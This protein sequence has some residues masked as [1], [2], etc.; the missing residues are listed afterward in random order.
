MNHLSILIVENE[1][2]ES[3]DI[4]QGLESFNYHVCDIAD[5]TLDA[6]KMVEKYL[7]DLVL[8]D[9]NL[10]EKND[11]I[12]ATKII[13]EKYNIPV[14][15]LTAN[16]DQQ[17]IELVKKTRP[18]GFIVKP[19]FNRELN[20]TIKTALYK[21]KIE[22]E[23]KQNR[24][25]LFTILK[26]IR[27][28]VLVVDMENKIK[29]INFAAEQLLGYNEDQISDKYIF[30]YLK[31][32]NTET[33]QYVTKECLNL[34]L[35]NYSDTF[36][37]VSKSGRKT[38]VETN[39]APINDHRGSELGVVYAF[40]DISERQRSHTAIIN[41]EKRYS[42]LV[43]NMSSGVVVYRSCNKGKDFI[44]KEFNKAAEKIES[45]SHTKVLGKNF[46]QCFPDLNNTKFLQVLQNVW[47]DGKPK[48][49][50]LSIYKHNKLIKSY[51]FYVYRLHSGEVISVFN[52]VKEKKQ[53]NEKI[54][55]QASL[56]DSIGEAVVA[57]NQ[58]GII[59]YWNKAA[60]ELYGWSAEESLGMNI[61]QI[62]P[63][64][65]SPDIA[66]EIKTTLERGQQW[67]GE[68][69]ITNR[70][71]LKFPVL[72]IDSPILDKTGK[73]VGIIG[74]VTDISDRKKTLTE[75]QQI[76]EKQSA[77]LEATP[78]YMLMVNRKM[79]IVWANDIAMK[80]YGHNIVGMNC[81]KAIFGKEK[82]SHRIDNTIFND[83]KIKERE[84]SC[85]KNGKNNLYYH[86]KNNVVA[87]DANQN[88]TSILLTI[89]DITSQ[90]IAIQEKEKLD[91][92]LRQSQRLETI[93][94]LAGGIAH[95]FNNILTPIIGYADMSIRAL[96]PEHE[97]SGFIKEIKSAAM[98]AKD[99]V[100]QILLFSKESEHN[101]KPTELI[102]LFKEISRLIKPSI[103]NSIKIAL[104]LPKSPIHIMADATQIHQVIMN[105]CANAYQAMENSGGILS[106]N[107]EEIK[108]P[109]PY[110]NSEKN[111]DNNSFVLIKIKDTGVGISEK[112]MEHIFEP[113][114]TTKKSG[115]GLGL[116]VV[117][118]IVQSHNGIL[119]IVSEINQGTEIQIFFPIISLKPNTTHIIEKPLMKG[120]GER[121]L[122]IDDEQVI[123]NLG[124]KLLTNL[125]YKTVGF[126]SATDA[127]ALFKKQ[128][129]KFDLVITDLLMPDIIGTRLSEQIK[130]IRQDIPIMLL[131]GFGKNLQVI[132]AMP[133]IDVVAMKPLVISQ[134]GEIV[135]K[136][137][138]KKRAV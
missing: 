9:I 94:T 65:I 35:L 72:I 86:I 82:C 70:N 37:L 28:G 124:I 93:G 57:T 126:T 66:L 36:L 22:N 138:K 49:L 91:V 25:W 55:L 58:D 19:F 83:K 128:P 1:Y 29:F 3:L 117:H 111:K 80:T 121:I 122:F 85:S 112:D 101:K 21:H 137:I 54:R 130:N 47:K 108:T 33:R 5:N 23:L 89:R 13:Q 20:G 41:K 88:P 120:N 116:S 99:L 81:N 39:G 11:G 127:L 48:K 6:I 87:C 64:E 119:N 60:E 31:L 52:D 10:Q 90:K 75:L 16:T 77:I 103:P 114:Y 56:L 62:A 129:G 73:L 68:Y 51:E 100:E 44:I 107:V 95:D 14:V 30:D 110:F 42:E 123:M 67:K 79:K 104:N 2:I 27:D 134:I 102:T 74:I 32:Y 45:V 98:R 71:N 46:T 78:D 118:G 106:I 61:T 26:S 105:L 34:G 53:I 115:N 135:N 17:T 4:K 113:F 18:F 69:Y 12:G 59:Y 109:E 84:V 76:K 24:A 15:Y 40:R 7:P 136:I 97:V 8:M 50:P 92:Q 43:N 133:T 131:T 125:G 132:K 63:A 96:N 38:L